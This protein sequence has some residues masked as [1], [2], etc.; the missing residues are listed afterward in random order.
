MIFLID[1]RFVTLDTYNQ[2]K[3]IT[4]YYIVKAKDRNNAE[5][6]IDKLI[7]SYALSSK[8][9]VQV[10]RIRQALLDRNGIGEIT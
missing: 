4:R 6:K 5:D 9:I 1:V 7:K 2:L 10:I 3:D 8:D